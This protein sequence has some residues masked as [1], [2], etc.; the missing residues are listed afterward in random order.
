MQFGPLFVNELIKDQ[1]VKEKRT[2]RQTGRKKWTTRAGQ[3]MAGKRNYSQ[4]VFALARVAPGLF[5]GSWS[6]PL[7]DLI[8][9]GEPY[10]PLDLTH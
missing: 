3:L 4:S 9:F 10:F 1:L 6:A 2:R 8:P 7:C 5:V